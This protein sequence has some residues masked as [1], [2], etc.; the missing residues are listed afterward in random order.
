[1][2]CIVYEVGIYIYTHCSVQT[3]LDSRTS[4]LPESIYTFIQ[5]LKEIL[6]ILTLLYTLHHAASAHCVIE[7]GLLGHGNPPH[8]SQARGDQGPRVQVGRG[9][10]VVIQRGN[11]QPPSPP[12]HIQPLPVVLTT[13]T[14]AAIKHRQQSAKQPAQKAMQATSICPPSTTS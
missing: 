4:K 7:P 9:S 1:M 11:F 6:S 2:D 3:P 12:M 10:N 8:T 13:P 14:T 5:P